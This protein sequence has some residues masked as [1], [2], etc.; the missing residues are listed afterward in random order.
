MSTIAAPLEDFRYRVQDGALRA[1]SDARI[2]R[3]LLALLLIGF[4]A[5]WGALLAVTEGAGLLL[6]VVAF[7][8]VLILRDFR[9]GVAIMILI[10]PI[11]Q[12]Y[13]FPHEM[14][15]I[16]GLNPLNLLLMATLAVY[17][18]RAVGS[19]SLRHF[20]PKPLFLLFVVPMIVAA[21]LG[22][23]HVGEIPAVYREFELIFFTDA[24]GYVRD[25]LVKPL[26]FVIFALLVAAAFWRSRAPERFITPLMVSMWIMP[27]LVVGFLVESGL[28]IT[29]LSGTY[30]RSLLDPLG[31]H[32]NDVA[33]L[34]VIAYAMLLFMWDRTRNMTL[35]L[36]LFISMGF[37]TAALVM[38]FSRGGWVGW[39][40]VNMIYL[41]SR[42]NWRTIGLA[43]LAL[44][45]FLAFLPGAVW[46]RIQAGENGGADGV[47]AGRTNLIWEPLM[48][49]M[50]EHPVIGRGLGAVMFSNAARQEAMPA[51]THP[52]NAFLEA[53]LDLGVVGLVIF[54][55]YW[56]GVWRNLRRLGRDER[57]HPNLRG[58]F[59]GGA[60]G[61]VSFLV[62]GFAGS[63][64]MP[65]PEQV[66]LWF[67]VGA[68]YGMNLRLKYGSREGA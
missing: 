21:V 38:T 18:M 30:N 46:D 42:R 27:L 26:T 36:V 41:F 7:S 29:A 52:H 13:M 49:E 65:V 24:T 19:R 63:S 1:W 28:G 5:F 34:F 53:Y 39:I 67:A 60:A 43:V 9:V 35:K 12:S 66:F 25:M 57:I 56:A 31:L 17:F 23:P 10:M 16:T 6:F 22:A 11:A 51:V 33:R 62:A 20:I 40:L 68:M 37:M 45:V 58:L 64:L 4:G 55:A 61:L 3:T 8:T 32:A 54:L 48:P 50:F 14:F 15:G 59:E 2:R 47:T 44:P